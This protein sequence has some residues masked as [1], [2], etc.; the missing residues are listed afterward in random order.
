MKKIIISLVLL[1]MLSCGG[2][3]TENKTTVDQA[4]DKSESISSVGRYS[5]DVNRVI[6]I[7]NELVKKDPQLQALEKKVDAIKEETSAVTSKYI[8]IITQSE[9][10]YEDAHALAKSVTDS[11]SRHVVE[12]QISF[13]SEQYDAKIKPV[14]DLISRIQNNAVKIHDQ[15]TL[16]MISKT[17]PEIR[18]YQDAHILKPDSLISFIEKQNG[19]LSELKKMK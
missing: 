15:H 5:R 8:D 13:S 6:S 19:L 3:A 1:S 10:Y 11:A 17:L 4:I 16:F 14:R 12:K 9:T 7:Y 18:K 2:P